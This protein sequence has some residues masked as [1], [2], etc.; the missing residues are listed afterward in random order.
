MRHMGELR[1]IS[2]NSRPQRYTEVRVQLQTPTAL[3]QKKESSLTDEQEALQRG[4]ISKMD[5][6]YDVK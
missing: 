1:Y 5:I 3:R 6:R 2:T 4:S